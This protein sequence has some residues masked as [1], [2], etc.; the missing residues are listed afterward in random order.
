MVNSIRPWCGLRR[1]WQPRK[2]LWEPRDAENDQS[3]RAFPEA[4][5]I[6][7]MPSWHEENDNPGKF[8]MFYCEINDLDADGEN[9]AKLT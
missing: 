7:M 3:D 6:T 9:L 8:E 1:L 5:I 2:P 4:G